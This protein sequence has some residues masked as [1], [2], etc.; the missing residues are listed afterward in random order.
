[1]GFKPVPVIVMQLEFGKKMSLVEN[2]VS[3]MDSSI[4]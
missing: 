1:M 2:L 3:R 4:T